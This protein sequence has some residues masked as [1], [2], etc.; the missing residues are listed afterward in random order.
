MVS[1]D[2]LYWAQAANNGA[3]GFYMGSGVSMDPNAAWPLQLLTNDR[4]NP[5][6]GHTGQKVNVARIDG[7]VAAE[8]ELTLQD[9]AAPG[10]TFHW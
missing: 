2:H 4:P 7:S 9:F 10:M 5:F 1:D 6:K 3:G 8:P